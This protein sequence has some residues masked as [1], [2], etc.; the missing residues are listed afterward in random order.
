M[1]ALRRRL[2]PSRRLGEDGPLVA[3]IL[4]VTP[5]SFSDGGRFDR[6]EAA[7]AHARELWDE[8]A[9]WLDVGGESTRPGAEPVP[10]D[11]EIGRVVPVIAAL[12]TAVPDV[13]VSIDTQKAEVAE[14]ALD[15][16]ATVVNDVSACADPAMA[17]LVAERGAWVILMHMRGDPRTMQRD[18]TYTDLVEEVAHHLTARV[19]AVTAAG[20]AP[21]RIVLDPG[22]G[23]G[24][25]LGD[26]PALIAATQR[27]RALGHPVMI[28]A[29][30]KR[31]IG[32]LTGVTAAGDRVHGSVG[33]A[34]AAMLAGADLLRVHDVGATIQAL[35]VARACLDGQPVGMVRA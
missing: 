15:A 2:P 7:V 19:A 35:R 9:D 18:T 25:A 29:S 34:L 1:D 26:N 24:K 16:G 11:V 23:F 6:V 30:R 5:D 4:N 10:A 14:A 28:G 27:F 17:P 22:V 33:A 3:G 21:E 13:V 31:F 32:E 20:V 8:G 12:R